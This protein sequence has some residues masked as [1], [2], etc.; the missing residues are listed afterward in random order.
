LSD[1]ANHDGHEIAPFGDASLDFI[2][3]GVRAK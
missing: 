3:G 2:A 1:K